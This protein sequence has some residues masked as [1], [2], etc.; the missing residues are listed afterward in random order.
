[1]VACNI[2]HE[3]VRSTIGAGP[4]EPKRPFWSRLLLISGS[5]VRVLVHPPILSVSQ[6]DK[7]ASAVRPLRFSGPMRT[8]RNRR[9]VPQRE[10]IY[11]AKDDSPMTSKAARAARRSQSAQRSDASVCTIRSYLITPWPA[12]ALSK[13]IE[14]VP[15]CARAPAT[16]SRGRQGSTP[17]CRRYQRLRPDGN[18]RRGRTK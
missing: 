11:G 10:G 6:T 12:K 13:L 4:C 3:F 1:M 7:P 18:S 2:V 14:R 9:R 16:R 8:S 17:V 15:Q 5:K